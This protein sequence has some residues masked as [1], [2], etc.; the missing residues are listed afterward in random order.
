L[1]RIKRYAVAAPLRQGYS[2][3]T[4]CLAGLHLTFLFLLTLAFSRAAGAQPVGPPETVS[5]TASVQ[6]GDTAKPGGKVTLALH[7]TVL[8]GWHVY[9]LKQLPLGPNPFFVALDGGDIAVADGAPAESKAIKA[10]DAA[11]GFETQYYERAFTVTLPVRLSKSAAAGQQAI[12][13]RVRFQTC[14]GTVCQPPKTVRL[15]AQVTVKA[16]G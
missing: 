6:S 11:F 7:G 10:K 16:D 5:W 8:D 3:R 9:S 15:S 2:L 4:L 13:V 1:S 12:P 14:N